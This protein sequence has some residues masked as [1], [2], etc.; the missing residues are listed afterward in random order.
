VD[1]LA[2]LD[3]SPMPFAA[4]DGDLGDDDGIQSFVQSM[5]QSMQEQGD[6]GNLS[7]MEVSNE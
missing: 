7:N 5:H 1:D 3:D 4:D 2:F 6:G